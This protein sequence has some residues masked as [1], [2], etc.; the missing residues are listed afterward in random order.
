MALVNNFIIIIIFS[1]ILYIYT[2]VFH[3]CNENNWQNPLM[4]NRMIQNCVYVFLITV[5]KSTLN[6]LALLQLYV[7]Y[8]FQNVF[9]LIYS[10]IQYAVG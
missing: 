10:I 6:L 2:V 4:I 8:I 9:I 7:T 3:I 1:S 5:H